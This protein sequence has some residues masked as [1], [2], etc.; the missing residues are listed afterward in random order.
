MI[1][2]T[3]QMFWKCLVDLEHE[4]QPLIVN[5]FVVALLNILEQLPQMIVGVVQLH[6][7]GLYLRDVEDV[8]D[9]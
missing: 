2:I 1:L 9:N 3:V 4:L 6:L 8:V 5:R 7:A